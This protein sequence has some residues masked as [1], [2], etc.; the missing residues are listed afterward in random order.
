M[1][2]QSLWRV[3]ACGALALSA[4][5]ANAQTPPTSAEPLFN[6]GP[7]ETHYLSSCG[8]NWFIQAGAGIT[9]P[10]VE[11]WATVGNDGKRHITANYGVG[12]GKW[13]SPYLG[14]RLA[15]QGGALHWNLGPM[16]ECKW[17]N[18]NID[19][20]WDMF[21]SLGEVNT[22]RFL[23]VVPFAGL[24]GAFTWD[25]TRPELVNVIDHPDRTPRVNSWTLPVSAGV[26]LRFRLSR[27]VD[28]FA[29]GRALLAG[30]NF[31]NYVQGMPVD[32][33]ANALGGFSFNL[34][35]VGFR[36]YNPCDYISY[37]NNLNGQVNELRG[38]LATTASALAA[39]QAQLPCPELPEAQPEPE[40]RKPAPVMSTVRFDF[41]SANISNREMVGVYN[42]AQ[43]LEANPDSKLVIVGYADNAT[44][45]PEYNLKLS[46]RRAEAVKAALVDHYGINPDRLT[47]EAMGSASQL[48]P[49]NNW[50]RIVIFKP[51]N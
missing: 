26:Q 43:W 5:A 45:T 27:Y 40:V 44:G 10:F 31:N 42:T 11:N 37:I 1:N 36:E 30:D 22:K 34:G 21:N 6:D 23:S 14:A 20:M 3:A 13:F 33:V 39:A 41:N 50:N 46:Q 29:E 35:G 8:D 7:C 19:L 49:T 25:Y 2:T 17:A 28:F 32:V 12:V 9:V 24:G 18:A 48:Y 15:M 47:V 51:V 4:L 16:A 38:A